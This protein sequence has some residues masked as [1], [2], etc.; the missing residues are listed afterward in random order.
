L[1]RAPLVEAEGK[2]FV[3]LLQ[4]LAV[5]LFVF[6][7][8]FVLMMFFHEDGGRTKYGKGKSKKR[9]EVFLYMSYDSVYLIVYLMMWGFFNV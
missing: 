1:K 5:T 2:R 7:C 4:H 6:V 8:V 3:H 9:E